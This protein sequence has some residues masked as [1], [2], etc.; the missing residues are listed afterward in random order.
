MDD[1]QRSMAAKGQ[2]KRDVEAARNLAQNRAACEIESI[3]FD[4]I[5][6]RRRHRAKKD[7]EYF[8]KTYLPTIFDM[9]FA[10][11]H[12]L[13]FECIQDVFQNRN[14]QCLNVTRGGGKTVC[15]NAGGAHGLLFGKVEWVFF[16][17]ANEKKAAESVSTL[18]TWFK[19]ERLQ[20]DF[21]ELLY[22]FT[23]LKSRQFG[24]VAG[25]Q[26]YNG[27]LTRIEASDLQITLPCI[28][29]DAKRGRWYARHDPE[30]VQPVTIP[31]SEKV[32]YVS[33]SS[34]NMWTGQGI[35]VSIRGANLTHPY[36]Q[37]SR[38]V[39]AVILDDIQNDQSA[40][41]LMTI[42]NYT[43]KINGEIRFLV[44]PG[45]DLG[46]LM[47]CTVI[48][49]N[50][51]AD[52]YCNREKMPLWRGIRIPMVTKWPDGITNTEITN[53]TLSAR[54]WKQYQELYVKSLLKTG[55]WEEA[56]A[57]YRAHRDAMDEGFEVSWAARYTRGKNLSAIQEAMN[58]RFEDLKNFLSNC[59]QVGSDVLE[60]VER[61]ISADSFS[62]KQSDLE[63]GVVPEAT[64]KVVCFIDVQAQYFAWTITAFQANG[65]GTVIDY[66]TFPDFGTRVY[67][68]SQANG[69]RMLEVR[70]RQ[71]NPATAS[72]TD[73]N[74][75]EKVNTDGMYTWG[76]QTLIDMLSSR[77]FPSA[78]SGILHQIDRFGVD[79]Q[80]GSIV[81]VIRTVAKRY[82]RNLVI[83]YHGVGIR[84]NR[85]TLDTNNPAPNTLHEGMKYPQANISRWKYQLSRDSR[86][87]EI[88]SDVNAW[89]DYL[90]QRLDT[91]ADV[92]GAI[93]LYKAAPSEHSQFAVQVCESEKPTP[94][95][96]R[97]MTR[98]QWDVLPGV[99]N[100]FLDCLTASCCIA[101][102]EGCCWY[103][104]QGVN[105]PATPTPS[106]A[107]LRSSGPGGLPPARPKKSYA[108]RLREARE[109]NSRLADQNNDFGFYS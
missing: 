57:F 18:L 9:P 80:E 104:V 8:A 51:L 49:S 27:F 55:T 50:D 94:M 19:S 109:R 31:G 25:T 70:Y 108:D 96:A 79:A 92:P 4:G 69:W 98:N 86:I 84:A 85:M 54:L 11:Y 48:R 56:T 74:G 97:D 41:S 36:T 44:K 59:Q 5:N 89:K 34:F 64:H 81:N 22:P 37:K 101:S 28:L 67:R 2:R 33:R 63:K 93:T 20:Q 102:F 17:G 21:P 29:M 12:K 42:Q 61:H 106:P 7:L 68:R 30:S 90:F 13:L 16:I 71:A 6:W 95:T 73:A 66:G 46:M 99:D 88:W 82:P 78:D 87:Y 100:E 43:D 60:K 52:T 47:P 3:P 77:A 35:N 107:A 75:M 26:T 105:R 58:L 38:R 83:P 32:W 40:R 14:K 45:E 1:K 62:Q 10:D 23:L 91:P 53:E 76:L 15:C 39:S 103:P 72:V 65:T 24:S